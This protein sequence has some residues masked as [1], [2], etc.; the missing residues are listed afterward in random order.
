LPGSVDCAVIPTGAPVPPSVMRPSMPAALL[1]ASPSA[2]VPGAT[3]VTSMV[4][5]VSVKPPP[6]SVARTVML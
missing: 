6:A 3:L 1:V 2:G 5:T 4:N